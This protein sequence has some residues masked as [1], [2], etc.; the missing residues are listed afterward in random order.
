M[1]KSG[2]FWTF[3]MKRFLPAAQIYPRFLSSIIFYH[4]FFH[5]IIIHI[6]ISIHFLVFL[7]FGLSSQSAQAVSAR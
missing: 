7:V 4:I 3:G 2:V 5:E 6:S 1:E